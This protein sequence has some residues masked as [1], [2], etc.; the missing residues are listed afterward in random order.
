MDKERLKR[1]LAGISIAG[2][3]TGASFTVGGCE[4]SKTGQPGASGTEEKK[5]EGKSS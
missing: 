1:V 3:L 2:L 5:P 4:S